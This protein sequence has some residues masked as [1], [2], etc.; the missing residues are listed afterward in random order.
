LADEFDCLSEH[1]LQKLSSDDLITH[2]REA[3]DAGRPDC[4]RAALA[5]LCYRHLDDVRRRISMRVA[6]QDVED[7]AMTVMLA[8]LQSTFDGTSIGEFI[9]WL[10]RIVD[11]RGIADRYR[12]RERE[13]EMVPIADEHSDED[14]A[15]G[16][17]VSEQD[18][19]GAVDVQ[20]I[21]DACLEGL[22]EA[23]RDVVERNVFEDLNASD[24]ADQVNQDHPD[25][26]PPMSQANVHQIVSRFRECVR[27]RLGGDPDPDPD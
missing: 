18:A 9:N 1:E 11:R 5:I 19:T 21:I 27:E 14:E 7:T 26:D 2:I 23:H 12:R 20:S 25:L 17:V 4:A 13:P 3:A 15:W 22:S 10:N 24:T 8:A 6:P 16:E